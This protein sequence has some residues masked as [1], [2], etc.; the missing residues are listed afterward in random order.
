MVDAQSSHDLVTAWFGLGGVA[1][2]A[3]ATAGT[4]LWTDRKKRKSEQTLRGA[5]AAAARAQ[6]KAD[7]ANACLVSA[8][9]VRSTALSYDTNA[10]G[11]A[12]RWAVADAELDAARL[13]LVDAD[14]ARKV[15][16][17]QSLTRAGLNQSANAADIE[18]AWRECVEALGTAWN[19]YLDEVKNAT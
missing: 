3:A 7:A 4:G 19:T 18:D 6:S 5:E 16:Q 10:S 15:G 9:V 17:W 8:C 11:A 1:V 12:E 13:R 2:G 14:T